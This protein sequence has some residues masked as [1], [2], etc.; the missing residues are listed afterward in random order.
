MP[1][2]TP[3]Q[4]ATFTPTPT[5]TFTATPTYTPTST[6]TPTPT[7]TVCTPYYWWPIYSV[8]SGDTLYS[9]ALKTGS[10]PE[11]LRRANCLF[12]TIIHVGQKLYVPHL[13]IITPTF[14]PT[15]TPIFVDTP[16]EFTLYD[17]MSC[18][19]P[20]YVSFAVIGRDPEGIQ[21][22][23]VQMYTAA[24]VLIGQIDMAAN[25]DVYYGSGAPLIKPYTVYDVAYYQFSAVDGFKSIAVSKVYS[26]RSSY[27]YPI[28]TATPTATATPTSSGPFL[29]LD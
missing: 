2:D 22:V 21:S 27:C 16:T 9:I 5:D 24:G 1:T 12:G 6:D 7:V 19:P 8:Q 15:Y 18:D 17:V 26:D 11:E 20:S 29:G 23:I 13:P 4:I 3:T 10:T 25:G 14:T 28:P